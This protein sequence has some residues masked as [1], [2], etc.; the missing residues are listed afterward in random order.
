MARDG[1]KEGGGIEG[2]ANARGAGAG[3][4]GISFLSSELGSKSLS[5]FLLPPLTIS[6]LSLELVSLLSSTVSCSDGA[7]WS[8]WESGGC[9][10]VSVVPRWSSCGPCWSPSGPSVNLRGGGTIWLQYGPLSAAGG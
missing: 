1:M 4:G 6:G 5:S 10:V 8:D 7:R 3:G 2:V 9:I